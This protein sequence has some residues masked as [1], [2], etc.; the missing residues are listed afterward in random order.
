MGPGEVVLVGG[1]PC[2]SVAR[3]LADLAGLPDE[4]MFQRAWNAADSALL[5]DL[6]A[7]SDQLL[8]QPAGVARLR[9][10]LDRYTAAP[11]LESVLE[12]LFYELCRAEGLPLPTCQWPLADGDRSGRVDFV[13]EEHGV[14]VEVD[15]RKWHAIQAA[16][17]EDRARDLR[18]RELG[19][20]P[21][22]YTWRQVHDE[23]PRV[24]AALRLV[25]SDEVVRRMAR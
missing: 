6:A 15:G 16:Y 3:T 18:L 14:A 9:A 17:E 4:R 12:E 19:F 22:R 25:L 23:G 24:A 13:F 20:D 5:L 8:R 2:T 1:L 10:R 21:H 11:P 7:L